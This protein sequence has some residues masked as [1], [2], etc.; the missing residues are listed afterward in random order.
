MSRLPSGCRYFCFH[1]TDEDNE[2]QKGETVHGMSCPPR[3]F[4]YKANAHPDIGSIEVP[5]NDLITLQHSV[6]K[7]PPS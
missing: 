7:P 4:D 2:G 1:F 5:L 3:S 6:H